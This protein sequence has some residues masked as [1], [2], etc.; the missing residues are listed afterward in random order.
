MAIEYDSL[1]VLAPEILAILQDCGPLRAKDIAREATRRGVT[2][3]NNLG[4][5]NK[6]LSEY[7]TDSVQKIDG[8]RWMA[9]PQPDNPPSAH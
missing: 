7:L 9:K 4:S 8:G 1:R 2:H 5:V 6:V 3:A